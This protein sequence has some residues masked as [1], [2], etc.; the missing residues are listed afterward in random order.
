MSASSHSLAENVFDVLDV[1]KNP[2][3][4]GSYGVNKTGQAGD[5]I[6]MLLD[7]NKGGCSNSTLVEFQFQYCM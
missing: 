4:P 7:N 1:I 3:E 5:C 6:A 2:I